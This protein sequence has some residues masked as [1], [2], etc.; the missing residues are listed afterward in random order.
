MF[1]REWKHK[2]WECI[3]PNGIISVI[4]SFP[5]ANESH[6]AHLYGSHTEKGIQFNEFATPVKMLSKTKRFARF[7]MYFFLND[8]HF[9]TIFISF[10]HIVCIVLDFSVTQQR[11]QRQQSKRDT[12]SFREVNEYTEKQTQTQSAYLNFLLL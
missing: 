6:N 10:V 8:K 11:P 5:V 1:N 4:K 7:K 12:L 3:W 2:R 9:V